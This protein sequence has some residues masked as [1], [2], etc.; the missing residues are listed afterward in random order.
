MQKN[1]IKLNGSE[2]DPGNIIFDESIV[3]VQNFGV[4]FSKNLGMCCGCYRGASCRAMGK[5]GDRTVIFTKPDPGFLTGKS[6]N[7]AAILPSYLCVLDIDDLLK[8]EYWKSEM[9][10]REEKEL[11]ECLSEAPTVRSG[12]GLHVYFYADKFLCGNDF[13]TQESGA[14][15]KFFGAQLTIPPSV[16]KCGAKY[17]ATPGTLS[18]LPFALSKFTR[19]KNILEKHPD[20]GLDDGPFNTIAEEDWILLKRQ[21][22]DD[23]CVV[24]PDLHYDLWLRVCLL[25]HST[26]REDARELCSLWSKRGRKYRAR[27]TEAII[28]G[29]FAL[30]YIKG[31]H[32][33]ELEKFGVKFLK[34]SFNIKNPRGANPEGKTTSKE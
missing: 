24:N 14:E 6:S 3:K 34:L 12:R 18:T 8:F 7:F 4:Y 10:A 27:Q 21:L 29:V 22:L 33:I 5:H 28:D 9:S 30:P 25:L 1:L 13:P 32:Y 2:F 26:G 23:V 20:T 16:H 15:L 31:L 17:E 19:E 11:R